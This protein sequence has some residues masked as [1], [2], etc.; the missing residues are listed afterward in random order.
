MSPD[1]I[2][3]WADQVGDLLSVLARADPADKA[4]VCCQ[5]GLRLT[6]HHETPTAQAEIDPLRPKERVVS[7]AQHEP[8]SNPVRCSRRISLWPE[9]GAREGRMSTRCG[10]VPEQGMSQIANRR[11]GR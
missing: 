11:F 8:F 9:G 3:V 7:E 4:E 6:W 2:S 5:L 1:E 10:L